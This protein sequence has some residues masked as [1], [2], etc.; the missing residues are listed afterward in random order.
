MVEPTENENHNKGQTYF[1]R[2]CYMDKSKSKNEEESDD[3][4]SD[5]DGSDYEECRSSYKEKCDDRNEVISPEKK[6][7][8]SVKENHFLVFRFEDEEP[9]LA[10]KEEW[11][12]E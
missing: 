11:E 2:P 5:E 7:H 8:V 4:E 1:L 12:K 9:I 6:E 3:E 10:E